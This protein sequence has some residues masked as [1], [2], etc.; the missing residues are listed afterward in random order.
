MPLKL[1]RSPSL[2]SYIIYNKPETAL[3]MSVLT[4]AY[5]GIVGHGV[6]QVTT[7][8]CFSPSFFLTSKCNEI[9]TTGK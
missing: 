3:Y 5:C 1:L 9:K 6:P 7:I 4:V 2:L 8:I